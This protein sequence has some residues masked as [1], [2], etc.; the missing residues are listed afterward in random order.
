MSFFAEPVT[1][2]Y[3][4]IL[5]EKIILE[6]IKTYQLFQRTTPVYSFK[7]AE[8][9]TIL[10][11]LGLTNGQDLFDLK[12]KQVTIGVLKPFEHLG[13]HVDGDM[14]GNLT[15]KALNIPVTSC[16][17]VFMNWYVPKADNLVRTVE[18]AQGWTIP[19]LSRRDAICKFTIPCMEPFVV[20]PSVFHDII[21][22][23]DT[24]QLII[25]IR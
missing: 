1:F 18:S 11:T 24:D 5:L 17:D 23:S 6:F 13:I 8:R 15:A 22:T 14:H 4:R 3:N 16:K 21:N 20:N 12:I 2:D 19:A 10:S 7:A 9:D 25:S